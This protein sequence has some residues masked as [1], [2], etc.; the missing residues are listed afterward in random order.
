MMAFVYLITSLAE[1]PWSV[2]TILLG[3]LLTGVWSLATAGAM[4][5][6]EKEVGPKIEAL[7]KRISM[8][9]KDLHEKREQLR[10]QLID[11]AEKSESHLREVVQSLSNENARINERLANQKEFNQ[12]VL[13]KIEE[14]D[15]RLEA[16]LDRFE[17]VIIDRINKD[18]EFYKSDMQT[19]I[20]MMTNISHNQERNK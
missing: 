16:R 6:V 1:L 7:E 14:V 5:K 12:S 10:D 15:K 8:S 19:L 3:L 20:T 11:R 9:S 13:S 4:R 18:H 2:L 17:E